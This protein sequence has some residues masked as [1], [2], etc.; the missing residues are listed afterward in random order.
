MSAR[1]ISKTRPFKLSDACSKQINRLVDGVG[2]LLTLSSRSVTWSL[3]WN[4]NVKSGWNEDLVPFFSGKWMLTTSNNV[5][6]TCTTGAD[7][8]LQR[9]ILTSSSWHSSFWNFSCFFL[10]SFSLNIKL[11]KGLYVPLFKII[12]L[13][14]RK[15]LKAPTHPNNI[16]YILST[17][18]THK[19]NKSSHTPIKLNY[20]L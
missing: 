13:I 5:I 19:H 4:S 1:L 14:N 9:K 3:S 11:T 12:D 8:Q 20:I 18:S 16:N 2:G 15:H 10:Q 6:S 17:K 7:G